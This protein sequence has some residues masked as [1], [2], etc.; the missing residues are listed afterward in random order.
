[1]N[2]IIEEMKSKAKAITPEDLARSGTEDG[3]QAALFCWVAL[4]IKTYPDLF[5]LFA[6]P[7]GGWRDPVTANKLKAT[8]VKSGVP[9]LCLL[10]RRGTF[11][12]LWIE[13][14]R[15]K[16]EGKAKGV[17]RQEQ[18]PWIKQA[19]NCGHG[20]AVCVGWEQARDMIVEYLNYKE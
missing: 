7:N 2:T 16:S 8:G 18:K 20:A 1:M 11:A 10:V 5:W 6:I 4:N 9:D 15:P 17:V 19:K 14:K 3:H 12:A 13:L